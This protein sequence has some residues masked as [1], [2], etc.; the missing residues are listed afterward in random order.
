MN[1][2]VNITTIKYII[3]GAIVLSSAIIFSLGKPADFQRVTLALL[4]LYS[5]SALINGLKVKKC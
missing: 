5:D 2:K 4:G 1:F 3:S